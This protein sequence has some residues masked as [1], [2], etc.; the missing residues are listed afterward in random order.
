MRRVSAP[1]L[2]A[3]QL[4][5]REYYQTSFGEKYLVI[6]PL[7]IHSL[8]AALK[9]VLS[10]KT[11]RRATSI[12]SVTGY[13]AVFCVL[14]HYFL[15]RVAP[16][17]PASP[18]YS[19]GPSELDFEYVKYGLHE[20]PV[21][22]FLAYTALAALVSAHASEGM[23]IIWNTWMRPTFGALRQSRKAR[24]TGALLGVV[25]VVSGLFFMWSEPL[26]VFASHAERFRASFMK[27]V[28]FRF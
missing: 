24:L 12:L 18:I 4:L 11:A 9:R 8:S 20:W 14:V 7:V 1:S 13:S 17:S 10:P 27:S 15:H 23:S 28:F 22:N 19:V 6:A 5:G 16:S 3:A 25:P 26:L 21:R 2:S